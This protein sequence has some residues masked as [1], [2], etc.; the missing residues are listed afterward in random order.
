MSELDTL[1]S[2]LIASIEGAVNI[3][4]LEKI[5]ILALGKKGKITELMKGLGTL[6][7]DARSVSSVSSRTA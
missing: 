5:R 1:R 3:D 4:G 2:E 7:E 6:E